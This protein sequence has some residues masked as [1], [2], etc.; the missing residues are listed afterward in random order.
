MKILITGGSSGLGK[1]ILEKIHLNNEVHFT[2]NSSI[3]SSKEILKKFRNNLVVHASDLPNGKGWSPLTWQILDGKKK[4]H[5]SLIEADE[6][7][8]SGKIY[9]KLQ[10]NVSNDK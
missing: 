7:V 10:I 8:D 9:K 4:I 3:D 2:Y 1:S 6:K 5:V